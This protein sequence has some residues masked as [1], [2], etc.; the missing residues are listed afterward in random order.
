MFQVLDI[1]EGTLLREILP[2]ISL[3]SAIVVGRARSGRMTLA[4]S[5]AE[6][7]LLVLHWTFFVLTVA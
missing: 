4:D 2:L 6:G 1:H 7:G 5:R 3:Q